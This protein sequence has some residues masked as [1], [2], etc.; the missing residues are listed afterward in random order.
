M[1]DKWLIFGRVIH[2]SCGFIA[3]TTGL[4]VI[5]IKKGTPS[6]KKLGKT[7][8]LALMTTCIFSLLLQVNRYFDAILSYQAALG[9]Y[10]GISGFLDFNRYFDSRIRKLLQII[11]PILIF[12]FCL[13]LIFL[14]YGGKISKNPALIL[15]SISGG[16]IFSL[17]DIILQ[18]RILLTDKI[19]KHYLLPHAIK[20][21]TAFIVMLSAFSST[22]F[23]F[24][25]TPYKE[26][27]PTIF[28]LPILYYWA[29]KQLRQSKTT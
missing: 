28:G 7:F 17:V 9:I 3:L 18:L 12:C 25:N 8:L 15:A 20:L 16:L 21:V 6:H 27:W 5:V 2:I 10:L 23:S 24:L 14:A 19:Q 13:F 11:L 1:L 26:T 22:T 29:I 4:I